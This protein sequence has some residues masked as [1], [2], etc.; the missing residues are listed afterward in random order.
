MKDVIRLDSFH[1]TRRRFTLGAALAAAGLAVPHIETALA[2]LADI[3][4]LGLPT[5]DASITS[6]KLE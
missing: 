4:S 1:L 3:A 2:A 5:I 6:P